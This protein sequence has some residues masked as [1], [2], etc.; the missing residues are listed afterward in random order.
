MAPEGLLSRIRG[1][2]REMPGLRLTFLQACRLWQL[3]PIA[4]DAALKA[5]V[6]ESFLV[7]TSDGAFIAM[8]AVSRE[9][10]RG[11]WSPRLRQS[12]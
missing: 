11:A 1:E 5:L 7:R 4:C 8:P 10:N 2:Y 12:A 3:D 6:A 9:S